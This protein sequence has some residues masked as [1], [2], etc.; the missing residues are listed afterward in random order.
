MG[1]M[2]D[3]FRE[4]KEYLRERK[5]RLGVDCPG[6]KVKEPK[7]IPTRLLPGQRCRVCGHVDPRRREDFPP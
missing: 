5:E 2:G 4:H 6:C 1:D 7:R 3:A